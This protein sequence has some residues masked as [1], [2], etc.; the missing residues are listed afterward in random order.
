MTT[1]IL[2]AALIS[3]GDEVV[4]GRTVDTNAS[5]ISERLAELGVEVTTTIVV[6]DYAE[7]I[8]WAWKSLLPEVDLVLSTGG[9]GPTAD[10][11]T[12][13]VLASVSGLELKLEASEAQRIRDIFA[14]R[15]RPMPENNLKQAM[16]PEG[17]VVIPNALGTAPGYRLELDLKGHRS[18]AL[19]LPG[20]PREMKA[21]FEETVL[22]WIA[23]R[24]LPEAQ[25]QARAFQTFGLPES[26]LDEALEGAFDDPE[27][28][29]AFRASFP[30]IAVRISTCGSPDVAR[31]RLDRAATIL[32]ERLGRAV[33]AEGEVGM[34]EVVGNLLRERGLT[35]AT[36]ESCTGGLIGH[37]LTDVAGSSEYYAGGIVAYSNDL[38]EE[39]LAVSPATLER[40]GAVSVETACEM[41]E[42]AC[43]AAG[44]DLAVATT[45]IAGPGGGTEEKPVG[46][47]AVALAVREGVAFK[48]RAFLY[49]L[50]GSRDWVKMLT[51]QLALDWARCH[52]IGEEPLDPG[53]AGGKRVER[54]TAE[55][56]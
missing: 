46:T 2:K 16:I 9:L 19:V 52:L 6:G 41:A 1:P 49:Q 42:G 33:F 21:M 40:Y 11:L 47:V 7:R 23:S 13:E 20:V 56:G 29:L 34:E 36:A 39:L 14:G 35:L 38:K 30:R 17:A 25:V 54:T 44:A 15:G 43:A 26:A 28:R 12:S 18:V 10:D 53:F 3:T 5:W 8:S 32:R 27:L 50:W 31:K 37:R 48:T 45:G 22:P 55:V 24:A 4:G 51:S